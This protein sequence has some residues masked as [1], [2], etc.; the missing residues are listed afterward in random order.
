M[1]TESTGRR[2]RQCAHGTIVLVLGP[3]TRQATVE[4]D[5]FELCA[6]PAHVTSDVEL[7][8]CD[9]CGQQ[10]GSLEG[11]PLQVDSAQLTIVAA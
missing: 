10:Y 3:V 8:A 7:Y 4:P 2:C 1:K 11:L 6:T 5:L 9:T